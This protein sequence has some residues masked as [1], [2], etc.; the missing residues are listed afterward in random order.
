MS[1]TQK[2]TLPAEMIERAARAH[3]EHRVSFNN[4]ADAGEADWFSWRCLCGESSRHR[5]I[6]VEEEAVSEGTKHVASVLLAA[7]LDGCEVR[8]EWRAKITYGGRF[9][10]HS[11][12]F[13]SEDEMRVNSAPIFAAEGTATIESRLV[14]ITPAED[15]PTD[16]G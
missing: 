15:V 8:E 14:I 10:W 13:R 4:L 5:Q 16:G 12:W 6:S 7:A 2:P 1:D 11:D 9:P 3:A